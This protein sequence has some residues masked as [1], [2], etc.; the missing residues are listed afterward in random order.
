MTLLQL[1]LADLDSHQPAEYIC[2]TSS[3]PSVLS[4]YLQKEGKDAAA[5][6]LQLWAIA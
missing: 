2:S 5:N 6:F 4:L 1:S 3:K